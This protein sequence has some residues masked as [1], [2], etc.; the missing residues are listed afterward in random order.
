[1]NNSSQLSIF[2]EFL[3]FTFYITNHDKRLLSLFAFACS[4]HTNSSTNFCFEIPSEIPAFS[5]RLH[6]LTNPLCACVFYSFTVITKFS[7]TG[8]ITAGCSEFAT[9]MDFLFLRVSWIK[10][11]GYPR[12]RWAFRSS[13]LGA[14]LRRH[15]VPGKD[16]HSKKQITALDG[17]RK[18]RLITKYGHEI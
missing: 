16:S 4:L 7:S 12:K 2:T 8:G 11:T 10:E 17:S 14:A 13:T 15:L 9:V 3:C 18:W 6:L 1:M 5:L